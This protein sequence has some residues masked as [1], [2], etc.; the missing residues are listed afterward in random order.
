MTVVDHVQLTL[1]S[2]PGGTVM[3]DRP[4]KSLGRRLMADLV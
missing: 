3:V 2:V 1:Y 4:T